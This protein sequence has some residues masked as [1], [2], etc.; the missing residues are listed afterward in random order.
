MSSSST[1]AHAVSTTTSAAHDGKS[2]TPT[3]TKAVDLYA[4]MTVKVLLCGDEGER[5]QL[6]IRCHLTL[7]FDRVDKVEV[8]GRVIEMLGGEQR[9]FVCLSKSYHRTSATGLPAVDSGRHVGMQR[10]VHS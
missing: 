8:D 10:G 1:S 2:D 5:L 9:A 4:P 3:A 7:V 6:T